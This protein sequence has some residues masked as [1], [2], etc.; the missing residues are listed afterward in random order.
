MRHAGIKSPLIAAD[1]PARITFGESIKKRTPES[2]AE[3]KKM[4]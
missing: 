2:I 4:A 1:A 3:T